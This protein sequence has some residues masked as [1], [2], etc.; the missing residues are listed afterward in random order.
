M[1]SQSNFPEK[2]LSKLLRDVRQGH[3]EFPL[4][5][6]KLDG[7]FD[8]P[9]DQLLY[10]LSLLRN[11][12]QK[13][14]DLSLPEWFKLLYILRLHLILPVIYWQLSSW[15]PE[16]RPPIEIITELRS[17]MMGSRVNSLSQERQL[18]EIIE[19]FNADGIRSIVLKGA[20][21]SLFYPDMAMRLCTDIDLLV[22][23]EDVLRCRCIMERLG[24][25]C[26]EKRFEVSRE[27]YCEEV[28][29]DKR[30]TS[31]K[32]VVELH[33]DL[34]IFPAIRQHI[35][36]EAI[37]TR[38]EQKNIGHLEINIMDPV[39]SLIYASS[40]MI[41]HHGDGIRLN[42]IY[43]IP[44]LCK[45][46]NNPADWVLLKQRCVESG[47][48][49]ALEKALNLGSYWTG[50]QIPLE[51]SDFSTWPAPGETEITAFTQSGGRG[52]ITTLKMLIP[53]SASI[54]EKAKLI[55]CLFFPSRDLIITL[56]P[57]LRG[58]PFFLIHVLRWWELLK[59]L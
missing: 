4:S 40:H 19:A 6:K 39:D 24:Y 36:L 12:P 59:K 25:S 23:P 31:G 9:D 56:Y 14:P 29:L 21:F 35:N 16:M 58:K 45:A 52:T 49:L 3:S 48:R 15:P 44:M 22:M 17:V 51:F 37:F 2:D 27:A 11:E 41:Y 20:A 53:K 34:I 30:G 57:Q 55:Y 18:R 46:L 10:V 38:A 54:S 43:D 42:W 13:P 1:D 8:L 7:V 47:A 32:K 26:L 50:M 33:W 28:F 5:G